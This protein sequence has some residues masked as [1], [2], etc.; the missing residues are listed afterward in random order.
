MLVLMMRICQIKTHAQ[1]TQG[2]NGINNGATVILI[3]G[4]WMR[5]RVIM[6]HLEKNV[7]GRL[8]IQM[9]DSVLHQQTIILNVMLKVPV[10]EN[11]Q[12]QTTL[13]KKLARM[14]VHVQ[15]QPI[16]Q[17]KLAIM[18]GRARF[19]ASLH[20][21]VARMLVHVRTQPILH[22]KLAIMLVHVRTRPIIQNIPV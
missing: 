6:L 15:T 5:L 14:L 20:N 2:A 19:Q 11:V 8:L 1:P 16:L 9:V 7:G 18:G 4:D 12:I 22:N 10:L 17:N 13:Q 21:K 3:V